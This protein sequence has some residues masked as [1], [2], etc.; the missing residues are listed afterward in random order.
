MR[1]RPKAIGTEDMPTDRLVN[2]W[3]TPGAIARKTRRVNRPEGR[4]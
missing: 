1:I 2:P 4:V 3:A